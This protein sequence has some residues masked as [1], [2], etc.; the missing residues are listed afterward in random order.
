MNLPINIK[1]IDE[2][3][4]FSLSLSLSLSLIFE[5]DSHTKTNVPP[6]PCCEDI[7][8]FIFDQIVQT[9]KSITNEKKII[10]TLKILFIISESIS[11]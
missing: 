11:I 2:E 1:L 4:S 8:G 7:F 5:I 10:T 6:S 9:N 3:L